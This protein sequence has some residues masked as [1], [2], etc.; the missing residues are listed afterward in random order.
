MSMWKTYPRSSLSAHPKASSPLNGGRGG[1]TVLM[2]SGSDDA[3][4]DDGRGRVGGDDVCIIVQQNKKCTKRQPNVM[5]MLQRST[6]RRKRCRTARVVDGGSGDDGDG[7]RTCVDSW[8]C[9]KCTFLNRN[10][11]APIC[12][13]CQSAR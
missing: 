8:M 10:I 6:A 1:R 7:G 3:G 4:D 12:E 2:S 5:E 11:L 13:V 9:A